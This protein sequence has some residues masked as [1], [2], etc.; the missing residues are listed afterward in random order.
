MQELLWHDDK[1]QSI[2][3]NVDHII[4]TEIRLKLFKREASII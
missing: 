1:K 2:V 3:E 4:V